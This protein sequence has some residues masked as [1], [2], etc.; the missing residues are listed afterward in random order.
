MSVDIFGTSWD[1]CVNMVQYSFTSAETIR[2][3]R[4]DSPGRPP[5]LSH[6]SWTMCADAFLPSG[7]AE[8]PR[9]G[10]MREYG[11]ILLYVHEKPEG[12][13]GRTAQDG[14]L[15]FHTAPELW[16]DALLGLFLQPSSARRGLLC[17]LVNCCFDS[18]KV[19]PCRSMLC[20]IV[21]CLFDFMFSVYF[22]LKFT[23]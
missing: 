20:R 4:T 15:D 12:S 7:D 14:H 23:Y 6:S 1:Q 9:M 2:L 19:I 3:V 22:R 5:R 11:S 13:L 8:C 18:I 21:F 17:L 10:P 16:P